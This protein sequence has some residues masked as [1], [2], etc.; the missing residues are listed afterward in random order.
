V[1]PVSGIL[2][3]LPRPFTARA[4][5]VESGLGN[6]CACGINGNSATAGGAQV[7]AEESAQS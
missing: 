5:Q 6:H 2:T 7:D 4:G 3:T 1:P